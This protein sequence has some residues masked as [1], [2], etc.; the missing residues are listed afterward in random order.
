MSRHAIGTKNSGSGHWNRVAPGGRGGPARR[1]WF[2]RG[3]RRRLESSGVWFSP[4]GL[5]IVSA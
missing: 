4:G 5:D 3:T 1:K 2:G